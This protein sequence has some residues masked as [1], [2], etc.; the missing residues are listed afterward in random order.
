MSV[1]E[2]V[3]APVHARLVYAAR[4]SKAIATHPRDGVERVR[5]RLAEKQDRR[6]GRTQ[7][8]RP[9]GGE[10]EL[11]ELLGLPWPCPERREFGAL[12]SAVLGTLAE[13]GV[14]TGRGTYGGWDDGDARLCRLAWCLARHLAPERVVETGVARGLT[15]RVV[16]EA[17]ERNGTGH[18]W[19]VDLPPLLERQRAGETGAAV[20]AE[21]RS[22][23]TLVHGSSRHVLPTLLDELGT[24]GLFVHDSMHTTRNV[25]FELEHVWPAL[26]AGGVALVDDV[27]RNH[28]FGRFIDARPNTRAIVL[29]AEDG[30][31]L[32][33]TVV[34]PGPARA[35]K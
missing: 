1:R 35:S 29:A 18:L 25:M 24:V 19:S 4:A 7:L 32:L 23:W 33:G 9:S 20:T 11:H 34:K 28:A 5:E 30:Q 17:L 31:A 22:R 6:L 16:L 8:S 15:T 26:V 13:R 3:M 2:P 12:W 21:L 10:R 14:V 27:E